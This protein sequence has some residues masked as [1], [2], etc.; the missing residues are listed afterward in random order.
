MLKLKELRRYKRTRRERIASLSVFV[1]ALP[2]PYHR[3]QVSSRMC[4]SVRVAVIPHSCDPNISTFSLQLT[5]RI[6]LPFPPGTELC[7]SASRNSNPF[8]VTELWSSHGRSCSQC[9]APF[10]NPIFCDSLRNITEIALGERWHKT[11]EAWVARVV[12]MWMGAFMRMR[13]L[14]PL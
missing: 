6:A 12:A 5:I 3:T 11:A 8:R 1:T 14:L 10:H 7:L 9:L 4:R 13:E 2:F